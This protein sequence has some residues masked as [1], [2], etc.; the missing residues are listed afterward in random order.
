MLRQV[1]QQAT[2]DLGRTAI[3]RCV[4]QQ[5][6][7]PSMPNILKSH[8]VCHTQYM[9]SEP[10]RYTYAYATANSRIS[11]NHFDKPIFKYPTPN[12][13]YSLDTVEAII[14]SKPY[15]DSIFLALAGWVCIHQSIRRRRHHG[16]IKEVDYTSHQP[17]F[18]LSS[19]RIQSCINQTI[20]PRTYQ[21]LSIHLYIYSSN[22]QSTFPKW[23]Q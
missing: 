14:S 2:R 19:L 12:I 8:S 6:H 7:N 1:G 13:P 20:R 22:H 21:S 17:S 15:W 16:H 11:F 10:D 18:N 4:F 5:W 23:V 9:V 3:D